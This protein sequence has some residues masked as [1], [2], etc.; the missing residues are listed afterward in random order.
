MPDLRDIFQYIDNPG[1]AFT[2][3]PPTTGGESGMGSSITA[4][5]EQITHGAG[6][7]AWTEWVPGVDPRFKDAVS[8]IQNGYGMSDPNRLNSDSGGGWRSVVDGSKLPKTPFGDITRAAPVTAHSDLYNP[9]LVYDDPNYGR[10]TD[11]RNF[12]P[13][14]LNQTVGM[15]LPMLAMAGI[16][17]LPGVSS[18]GTG[19]VGA[20]RGFMSGDMGSGLSSLAGL[21]GNYFGVPNWASAL[22]RF[23][24]SQAFNNSG[25]R[26][27]KN[28]PNIDPMTLYRM[29]KRMRGGY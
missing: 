2:L 14:K 19:I 18:L 4:P 12:K 10:I 20:G 9:N 6:D 13:D 22:G 25:K 3:N 29:R 24:I 1:T 26:F 7:N 11:A 23:G 16:G 5:W 21:L 27:N 17:A 15:L 28:N 8:F